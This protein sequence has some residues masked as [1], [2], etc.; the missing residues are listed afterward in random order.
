[1]SR[2]KLRHFKRHARYR[3]AQ[4]FGAT[5][6]ELD[7]LSEQIKSGKLIPVFRESESR[8]HY[9]V[10][11]AG[12]PAIVVWDKNRKAIV[13]VMERQLEPQRHPISCSS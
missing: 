6:D 13:T 10:E 7:A 12:K 1:M 11:L 2:N 5:N 4:R 8:R 9:N 3:A